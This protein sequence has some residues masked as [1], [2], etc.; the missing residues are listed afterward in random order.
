MSRYLLAVLATALLLASCSSAG[1]QDA[2]RDESGEVAENE[3][4]GVFRLRQGDCLIMPT[5]GIAGEEV[6]TLEAI[7]CDEPHSGEVL[8]IV[9]VPGDG[10]APYPGDAAISTQAETGCLA[11]FQSITGVEFALDTDWDMTFLSPTADSWNLGD[12]R[13]IV[14]IVLPLD[15]E[16]TTATVNG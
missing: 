3:D 1:E 11:D 7:P 10:D 16:P 14:C 13:E 15:G 6:E 12:D 2:T 5:A 8:S 9:T 4:I